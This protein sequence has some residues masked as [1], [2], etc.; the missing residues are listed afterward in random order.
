[1]AVLWPRT[2][3]RCDQVCFT[4]RY[5]AFTEP[6]AVWFCIASRPYWT[7]TFYKSVPVDPAGKFH[8]FGNFF[9]PILKPH[10]GG[11]SYFRFLGLVYSSVSQPPATFFV[12]VGLP[13]WLP[14]VLYAIALITWARTSRVAVK[15]GFCRNCGYD[16]RAT[17][18]RCPECGTIPP[19]KK[20][21]TST[22]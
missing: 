8:Q 19:T 6:N 15:V 10:I 20:A 17:P 7:A 14:A 1:M 22:T 11:V 9:R 21:I 2:L 13:L 4:R 12:Y 5:S 16:L 3:C 18:D